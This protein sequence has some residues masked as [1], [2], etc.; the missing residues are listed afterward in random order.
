MAV[1]KQWYEIM[2]PDMFGGKAIGETLAADPRKL[3][4]RKM[5]VSLVEISRDYSKFYFKVSIKIE[6]IEEN[7]A[8]TKLVGHE[9][10]RERVYR[11]VQRHGRRVDVIQDVKTKDGEKIRVKTVFMLL[12]RV[13][14]STKDAA[15]KTAKDIIDDFAKKQT[16]EEFINSIIAG[17]I[18]HKV[19]KESN[20]IY[21]I[22]S[23][24]IRKTE[25]TAAS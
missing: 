4:G 2:A 22:G 9:C 23:V 7:K 20:K 3:M 18:Q 1:K 21:P 12:R 16:S 14:K 19:K 11:M 5:N 15:R 25:F 8:F 13:G 10:L 17:D 6:K 24:E